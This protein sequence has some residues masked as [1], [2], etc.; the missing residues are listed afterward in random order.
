MGRERVEARSAAEQLGARVGGEDLLPAV[1]ALERRQVRGRGE[2]LRLVVEADPARRRG[3]AVGERRA[4]AEASGADALG[5][6]VGDVGVVAAEE[7]VAALA[8]ERDLDVLGGELRDEVRRERRR[9]GERLVERVGQRRQEQRRVRPQRQLAMD[10]A[11]ALGDG[12]RTGQLVERRLFEAD[13][14]RA[15]GLRRLLGGERGER[16]RVDAAR[17]EHADG[18]VGDQVRA[19]RVAQACAALLDELRL[20][21]A[22]PRR[23]RAGAGVARDRRR[24]VLPGERVARAAA[25]GCPRRSRAAPARS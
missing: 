21:L 6:Q 1:V 9:V 8:G 12:A 5:E 23:Q 25:C 2:A 7:L 16:A 19:H 11:V 17:E 4:P 20:V 24:A 22:V 13:R 3:Q 10:R 15:H 14:E 18:H